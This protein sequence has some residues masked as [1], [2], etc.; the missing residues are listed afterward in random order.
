MNMLHPRYLL[1]GLT[2]LAAAGLALALTPRHKAADHAPKINLETMIPVQFGE[3]KRDDNAAPAR[4]SPDVQAELNRIYNQL[5]DR[6][7][8][9]GKGERV[10]L[11]IALGSRQSY[12]MQVHRP[13]VCYPSLGFE[14]GDLSKDVIHAG[15][16]ALPVMKLVATQGMRIEPITYWVM[17]GDT[18]VR[19]NIEQHLARVKYGL[20]GEIP[21][22]LLIRVSMISADEAQTY[23]TQERFV[24]E[25]LG[26]MS[27][28]DRRVLAGAV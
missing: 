17:M 21:S 26:A 9:N 5:L 8:I 10:M 6:T 19:G 22:G 2:M 23:R 14:I 12:S 18:A 24:S 15:G 16:T 13:E 3:W 11:V 20:T 28:Q 4:Y 7:Y 27:A 1:I 25:M